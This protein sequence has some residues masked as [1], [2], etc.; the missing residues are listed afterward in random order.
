MKRKVRLKPILK[1]EILT[2]TGCIIITGRQT[3][4]AFSYASGI[5]N[6]TLVKVQKR[7]DI[8]RHISTVRPSLSTSHKLERLRFGL[9]NI[10]L[11][12]TN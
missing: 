7:G 8:V 9:S 12:I 1:S 3:Y 11:L 5:N 6:E 10:D 2:E 4:R